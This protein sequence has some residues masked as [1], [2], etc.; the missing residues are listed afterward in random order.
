MKGW[1]ECDQEMMH[2]ETPGSQP[3][4]SENTARALLAGWMGIPSPP[5]HKCM[6]K[7]SLASSTYGRDLIWGKKV[8]AD[9]INIRISGWD[10]PGLRAWALNSTSVLLRDRNKTQGDTQTLWRWRQTGVIRPQTKELLEPPEAGRGRSDPPPG[11][12]ERGWGV[13]LKP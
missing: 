3:V 5:T 4:Q 7:S 9:V 6:F 2:L 1:L 13:R 10:H 12:L 8:F 11:A